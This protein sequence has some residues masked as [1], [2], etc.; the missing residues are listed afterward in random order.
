MKKLFQRFG[1]K[2]L[3]MLLFIIF[4][5]YI[6]IQADFDPTYNLVSNGDFET[7]I[8]STWGP[9]YDASTG[10]V[11]PILER[12]SN[13][14][15]FSGN[16][17]HFTAANCGSGTSSGHDYTEQVIMLNADNNPNYLGLINLAAGKTYQVAIKASSDQPGGRLNIV[18]Q[19]PNPPSWT[20]FHSFVINTTT[21]PTVYTTTIT[22]ITQDQTGQFLIFFGNTTSANNNGINFYVDDIQVT[23]TPAATPPPTPAIDSTIPNG[24]FETDIASSWGSW[25]D[26]SVG[27]AAPT[28]ERVNNISGFSGNCLR[29][30]ASNCGNGS[31]SWMDYAEQ[32][33]ALHINNP[34]NLCLLSL[35]RDK[36]YI[37]SLKASSDFPG[38][39][40]VVF[41]NPNP[42]NYS[43][44][45]QFAIN[46]TTT[47]TVYST[48]VTNIT[49]DEMVQFVIL[50]GNTNIV[51]NN[52]INFY[53]DDVQITEQTAPPLSAVQNITA[54]AAGGFHTLALKNDGTIWG[55]GL[56]YF[57][58]L[59]NGM[60]TN[61]N[62]PI[63]INNVN[64]VTAIAA[65]NLF[66]LALKNDGTVWSWGENEY[67]QLGNESN[68]NTNIPGLVYDLN[69]IIAIAAGS[70]YSLALK[71][72]GTVWAW[73]Q[74]DSGQLG[75][76]SNIH[77]NIP[78]Q[79]S[80]L[81]GVIAVTGGNG[82]GLALKNDGTVWAW[83]YNASGELGNGSNLSSNIPVQVSGLS[84]VIA[85]AAGGYHSLALKNDGTVWAW[86]NNYEGELGNGS[87]TDSNIPVQVNSLNGV[88]EISAKNYNSQALKSDGT[89]WAW[90]ADD[91]NQLGDGLNI[92]RNLPV[93]VNSLSGVVA[94]ACGFRHG[95]VLKNDGTVWDWGYNEW[96][97]LGN[98]LNANSYLP[99]QA[100]E[101][102]SNIT[103]YQ[104]ALTVTNDGNGYTVPFGSIIVNGGASTDI[105]A[106]PKS[107]CDFAGWIQTGGSGTVI[108]DDP[109]AASTTV[110][111]TGG[112]A[113]IQAVFVSNQLTLTVNNNGYG[114][115]T[116]SGNVTVNIGANTSITATPNT[117]Y[118]FVNW[119]KTGGTGTVFFDDPA[120]ASTTVAVT[121]G[122]AVIQANFAPN[123]YTLTV[124]S[125]GN[126]STSPSGN[127][128]VDHDANTTI[129]ATPNANYHFV[130]WTKTSGT[131]TVVFS[132]PASA[133][134]TVTVTG[135]SAII[136]ANFTLNQYTLMVNNSGNGSTTPSGN[137]IVNS[138]A[139]IS[140]TATPNT[141]YHF[142][143]WTQIGGTGT[144]VFGNPNLA[145]TTVSVTGGNATVQ[146]NFALNQYTL[147]I[148]NNGYGSTT[149]TGN[150]MVNHGAQTS[151]TATPIVNY[152]FVN[153]TKTSGTG[154]VTFGNPNSAST[155]VTLTGGSATIR[156]NFAIIQYTMTVTSSGNGTTSPS[157]NVTVNSGANT[158]ITATPTTNYHFVNWIK[159]GGAG[160]VVFGNPNLASTT[161][162]IT[163][164]S[165]T[166]QAVFAINQYTL[167]V[168]NNGNGSTIPSGNITVNHGVSTPIIATPNINYHFINW[169]KT[170]GTGTVVFGNANYASTTVTVTGGNATIQ[171]NFASGSYNLVQNGYF[172]TDIANLW[173]PWND[174][175]TGATVPTLERVTNIPG[176]SGNCLRFSAANCGNGA[177]SGHDYTVQVMMLNANNNPNYLGLINLA[178]GKTYQVAIKASSDRPGR[179]NIVF[180]D[181]NPPSW[182]RFREF[183]VNTTTTP[184]VYTTTITN[185]TQDQ[186]G[187]FLIFFGNTTSANNNGNNFYVDD[188]Q[189]TEVPAASPPPPPAIDTAVPNGNMESSIAGSWGSWY[190][191]SLG[192]V[193]PIVEQVSNIPGFS[194]NCLRFRATNCGNGSAAWTDY[195]EQ[196]TSL[197]LNNPRNLSFLSI[198]R[199]K[200]Y[201]VSMKASSNI[202]G[203]L[204]IVFQNPNPPNYTRLNEFVINTT[205]TPTV[206]S[207]T[208][209]NLT[210]DE[211]V[212]LVI[213]FGNTTTVNNNGINFYIDD[214]QVTEQTVP[215][216]Q[217]ITAI[218]AGGFHNL[219]LKNDGT[220]WGWGLGY[221]GQLGNGLNSNINVPTLINNVS[222]VAVIAT[223]NLFS[224]AL[225]NDGTVWAW[226]ENEYGQLGNGSNT[227]TNIPGLVYD[228]N[229]IIAIAAGNEYSLALK[230]DGTV[231]AWGQNDSGQL[232]NGSNIHSNIP[233]QVSGLNGVIAVAGGQGHSM[234]LKNDGTVLAWGYNGSGELGNGSNID[235]N[236]PVQVSGLHGVIAIAAGGYHSLALK[237]D[238]TV[239]AWGLNFDGEL[240]NDSN[241]DS[242]I[243]VQVSSLSG[244][245]AISG[246]NNNSQALMS[247]G[248]VW[249][250]GAN[251]KN[252]LGDGTNISRN[253]PFQISSLS[254]AIAIATG[255]RHSLVLKNDGTVWDWGYNEWG[256]LGNGLN[257]DSAIPVQAGAPSTGLFPYQYA[258]TV[259]NDGNGFTTPSGS[260][261]VNGGDGTAIS[262]TPKSGYH[263]VN[264]T[265]TGGSG[266]VV[267]GDAAWASTMVTVTGGNV[268]IQANFAPN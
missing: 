187:Q 161:V 173:G 244:V 95:V 256:Q 250:W 177:S 172:E 149:P 126:G 92:N 114:S 131:G 110:T 200:S 154:T 232:G 68:T 239:W 56:G 53:I 225:K 237:N 191:S 198:K 90:G 16:C 21:T 8:A 205:T 24:D 196:I 62:I 214:V 204:N 96:G 157:G 40:N 174:P 221:F 94:L 229:G 152:Y 74:N 31:G 219:A 7:D 175:S 69:G 60:N 268:T 48:V 139:N 87:F 14:P 55:W 223:G 260:K 3:F 19:D 116:P 26:S 75:N 202:P 124:N 179:F 181:P 147:T 216:L 76:G 203:R 112:N 144:A 264:W 83:G 4:T 102:T 113:T 59:G 119:T 45:H 159:T 115:T 151:I 36:S 234:A 136:Q 130:N 189:V 80:G 101:P 33:N 128:T 210:A 81:N 247:D 169:T 184:T 143:N 158:S 211:M 85:I 97:Q 73:G 258:L 78:V 235:S 41:Q 246:K 125:G 156:A 251:D 37:V 103:P 208:V 145:S 141:N 9:W 106:T 236:I 20:R 148:T 18:F 79:V 64:N 127:I 262:A 267:F 42:P 98:G 255:G 224:L 259:S 72:D 218:A 122:N 77:S 265:Q 190:D 213:F 194:G 86:G 228:L 35:K 67:G 111:V 252:Q 209:T 249:V 38:R 164:G 28:L 13:I 5:F 12:V 195:A 253:I 245:I 50:F 230:N 166:I 153:W 123:Q 240:G 138:G 32:I 266:T 261:S 188:I 58:E 44:F 17:L 140:I 197:H 263:F 185:I 133:S 2:S 238:G 182:T 121:G 248:T 167:T 10:A 99:V 23:E 186:T 120:A 192:A 162:S 150:V 54:I 199:Y 107:G 180:Q 65:G 254:D 61:S 226:G 15:G 27:A 34:K 170:S 88:I 6:M 57:G 222:D 93:Q 163:G 135:G 11:T 52:G 129:T 91:Y 155:T 89:V 46:T 257:A 109:A 241:T 231:W 233:V 171:A 49:N 160:T 63:P 227:N 82:H 168:N 137:V 29:F 71:N 100:G 84:G 201:I 146:A 43:K 142:V 207:T 165:A 134:T 47:P 108:F 104:Y 212:Q 217:N 206:Y 39:L 105:S 1:K 51:N 178:A 118:H 220:I 176:F 132:D 183:V 66:S 243:P 22:N 193:T 25:N 70:E 215:P 117:N 242:N 30:S